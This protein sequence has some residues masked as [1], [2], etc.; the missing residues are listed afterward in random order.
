M[1]EKLLPEPEGRRTSWK[2]AFVNFVCVVH[3]P[4]DFQVFSLVER[5]VAAVKVADVRPL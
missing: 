2:F 5:L 1:K 3:P 4:M